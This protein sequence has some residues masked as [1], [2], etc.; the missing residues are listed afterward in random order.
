MLLFSIRHPVNRFVVPTV[1]EGHK[2][3]MNY[4]FLVLICLAVSTNPNI[5]QSKTMKNVSNYLMGLLLLALFSCAPQGDPTDFTI[6]FEKYTLSNTKH[7]TQRHI[8]LW[9]G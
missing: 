4:T 6:D 2:D 1:E 3:N 9:V 8:K 7:N 5:H